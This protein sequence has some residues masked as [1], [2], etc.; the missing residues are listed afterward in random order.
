MESGAR[1][2]SLITLCPALRILAAARAGRPGGLFDFD[3][4]AYRFGCSTGSS[5]NARRENSRCAAPETT[6]KDMRDDNSV[7]SVPLCFTFF[8]Q[9]TGTSLKHRGTED[10]ERRAPFLTVQVRAPCQ[11]FKVMS[12]C[13]SAVRLLICE[14]SIN[15]HQSVTF[16]SVS[17]WLKRLLVEAKGRAVF[18][19]C[20]YS[21]AHE[22]HRESYRRICRSWDLIR[23]SHGAHGPAEPGMILVRHSPR[24][25]GHQYFSMCS[26]TS[27]KP[28]AW[29]T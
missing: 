20:L 10:T 4:S 21:P 14:V 15:N 29:L 18:S 8:I 28:R 5:W 3:L 22:V 1:T 25:E 7:F 12:C 6:G 2:V 16:P 19:V 11:V 9:R 26:T 13:G 17:R 23:R 27:S 24:I